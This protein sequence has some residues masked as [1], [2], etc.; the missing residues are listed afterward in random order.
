MEHSKEP[1]Q[2]LP[3][4]VLDEGVEWKGAEC[5]VAYWADFDVPETAHSVPRLVDERGGDLRDEYLSWAHEFGT[6]KRH[7]RSILDQLEIRDGFSFWW[8]TLLAE[9]SPL[10]SPGIY[11]VF[12]LRVLENIYHEKG[13]E[14]VILC[15]GNRSLHRLLSEWCKNLGTHY[16]WNK[17]PRSRRKWTLRDLH[18]RLP[19]VL[20][21]FIFLGYFVFIRRR[22]LLH[23]KPVPRRPASGRDD[24]T[25][26]TYFDNLDVKEHPAGGFRSRYW[27]ALHDVLAD[28]QRTVNWVCWYVPSAQ[29]RSP[30][31]AL[32]L[33]DGF[34]ETGGDAQRCYFMDEW[35]SL[36]LLVQVLKD[37]LRLM[38]R[39]FGIGV[40]RH[41]FRLPGSDVSFDR[42]LLWDWRSSARGNIAMDGCIRLA[43]AEALTAALPT[44]GPLLY[45]L[46][47]QPWERALVYSWRKSAGGKIIGAQNSAAGFFEL[48]YF[49]DKRWHALLDERCGP[50][51]ADVVAVNGN[52]V[53]HLVQGEGL[54][55]ASRLRV[56][57]ALRYLY[58]KKI[59]GTVHGANSS[60]GKHTLL[61]VTDHTERVSRWQ[62]RLLRRT[63]EATE[64][65]Q[66]YRIIIKPHPSMPV[67]RILAGEAPELNV[68]ITERSLDAL[69]QRVDVVFVSGNSAAAVEA[70]IAG[71]PTVLGYDPG[72]FNMSPLR[73]HEGVVF[74]YSPGDL[75]AVLQR[76]VKPTAA[77]DYFCLDD[78]LDRWKYLLKN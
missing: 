40:E 62:I 69:W 60:E 74:A 39:S 28:D 21:A 49:E 23:R 17:Q 41:Y 56:V 22:F 54:C 35:L 8:M 75:A 61:V 55:P 3:L 33:R 72:G 11:D 20:Q 44:R 46:E 1:Q 67:T 15:S 14:G 47:N 76:P 29:C 58:L 77:A 25:V 59:A 63:F 26:I 68:E 19:H 65:L 36:G 48:R 37:Y 51:V 13:C 70:M 71:V 2:P 50:P 42:L 24:L 10:K 52:G 66:Q 38:L 5:V 18:H 31:D 45:L 73:G 32:R 30:Q 53:R 57:E 16:V 6:R 9:N 43:F 4:V 78:T 64:Q 12:R 7:G 27:N 34:S